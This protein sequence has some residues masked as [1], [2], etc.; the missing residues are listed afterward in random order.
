MLLELLYGNLESKR[1]RRRQEVCA[2]PRDET[3]DR[4]RD[5]DV[6]GPSLGEGITSTFCMHNYSNKYV[7]IISP[8]LSD[9]IYIDHNA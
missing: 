1:S 7:V 2:E 6:S 4:S 3:T 5:R 8:I 9:I